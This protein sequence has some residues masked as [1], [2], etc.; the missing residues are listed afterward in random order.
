MPPHKPTASKQPL[1]QERI[2]TKARALMKRGGIDGITFRSLADALGVT[3]MAI[4]RHFDSKDALLAE[5]FNRFV[6]NA[7]V[8]PDEPLPWDRWLRHVG[9]A[10]WSAM[11]AEPDWIRLFG[12]PRIRASSLTVVVAGLDVMESA[13]F[14]TDEALAVYF[15]VIYTAIG[16]ACLHQPMARIDQQQPFEMPDPV[17]IERLTRSVRSLD[18]LRVASRIE[19]SLDLL[20]DSLRLRLSAATRAEPPQ[21]AVAATGNFTRVRKKTPAT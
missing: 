13:G 4:Y 9:L 19:T 3:P 17:S 5:L 15:S 7:K 1:S 6:A 20:I 12:A 8:L 18:Q 11:V 10:M 16:A 14:A 21:A 2:L